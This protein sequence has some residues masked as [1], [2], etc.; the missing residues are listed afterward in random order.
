M[1]VV[2]PLIRNSIIRQNALYFIFKELKLIEN[3]MLTMQAFNT[4]WQKLMC[5][6]QSF[7]KAG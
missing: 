7:G 5:N 1:S 3:K 6:L 2:P 4:Y